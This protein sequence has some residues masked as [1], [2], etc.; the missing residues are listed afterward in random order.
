MVFVR[1][2]LGALMA[3]LVVVVA[4]PAVALLDLVTGGTGLGL[5]PNGLGT[6]TT[7][8]FTVMEL[9]IVLAGVA[10][11]LGGGIVGCL[12]LLRQPTGQQ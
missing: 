6:C 9:L 10:A 5:C 11:L 3:L 7:S 12:H 8:A 2:L 4:I 1:L